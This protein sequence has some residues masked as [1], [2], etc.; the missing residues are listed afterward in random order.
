MK[1]PKPLIKGSH[2]GIVA[3]SDQFP[4]GRLL[5]TAHIL[6]KAGF[7]VHFGK[8]LFEKHGFLPG[9]D[10]ERASDINNMF[11][12][13]Q[14]DA[15]LCAYGGSNANRLL[16]LLDYDLIRS[17][18]KIFLG[19]SDISTLLNAIHAKTGLV[20]YHSPNACSLFPYLTKKKR[21]IFQE[22]E[23][24][25][26]R[27]F[28]DALYGRMN[29][30]FCINATMCSQILKPGNVKGHILGGDLEAVHN[31]LASGI[32]LPWK[33]SIF[34]WEELNE[35]PWEIGRMLMNYKLSGVFDK[36][37]GMVVGTLWNCETKD[38]TRRNMDVQTVIYDLTK[39]YDFPIVFGA[40]F[41]HHCKNVIF[42]I[43][44]R[45]EIRTE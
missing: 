6:A 42:P 28:F 33:D 35:P 26:I 10:E 29:R 32:K 20:T 15:I 18:P 2:I 34:F 40:P 38:A 43:G 22:I 3:P 24:F 25:N 13:S 31:L 39:E 45:G 11:E 27:Y 37:K 30:P 44:G 41:G 12:E 14:I 21:K 7:V 17:H 19:M 9:T 5:R 36:I 1:Y 4:K 8:H 23:D 16:T